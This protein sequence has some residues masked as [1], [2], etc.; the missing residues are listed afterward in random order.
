MQPSLNNVLL[1]I[2]GRGFYQVHAGILA[3][4][5][6]VMIGAVPGDML[7]NYHKTLMIGMASSPVMLAIVCAGW[8]LYTFKSWH[9][10]TGQF[11]AADKQFLFYSSTS[12]SRADQLK[13]WFYVQTAI[14]APIIIYALMAVGVGIAHHFYVLPIVILAFLATIIYC[15]G[16]LYVN[17]INRSIDGSNQS[18]LLRF[19]GKWG[20]PYF[21]LYIYH[22][23]D[24]LKVPYFITKGLS[25]LIITSV[26]FLFADVRNDLRVAGI[27]VLA[28]ATA[29]TIL[30]FEERRFEETR[31]SFSKNLPFSRGRLFLN[32]AG[33]YL[34]LL[35]PEAIWLFTRFS[36]IMATELLCFVLS[37]ML[38][39]RSLLQWMGLN[40]DKYL[41][42]ILGVFIVLFWIVM[43]KLL[44]I[45]ILLNL[46]F[47][48]ALFYHNYY[49][50]KVQVE[51]E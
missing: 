37:V 22:I 6:F 49:K 44:G 24:K 12:F 43:F 26:F 47:A 4:G 20:K 2:F 17:V 36:L 39:Y 8:L 21:S 31:L 11:F 33:V 14:L 3:F 29:H 48:F 46:G 45:L 10:V 42:W 38:L 41:Q 25:W 5:F 15:S 30:I 50:E 1:K 27:A 51:V 34:V 35:L 7:V 28:V 19:S 18:L 16:L 40:M 23:F 13:S 9:Y 32:F